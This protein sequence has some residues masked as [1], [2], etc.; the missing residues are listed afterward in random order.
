M[1]RTGREKPTES[2]EVSARA[3]IG[4]GYIG[5]SA[6]T[7][8]WSLTAYFR[9]NHPRPSAVPKRRTA[10]ESS[11]AYPQ[12]RAASPRPATQTGT[13]RHHSWPQGPNVTIARELG[14]SDRVGRRPAPAS[15][16]TIR[17]DSK[18][19]V[20]ETPPRLPQRRTPVPLFA[21]LFPS[22]KQV[23]ATG[24]IARDVRR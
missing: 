6:R 19:F 7:P 8:P 20:C 23:L 18:T 24:V 17:A 3:N 1:A 11:T 21:R 4:R 5:E 9:G 10:H 15:G 16:V 12:T 22:P 13:G 14:A 2:S